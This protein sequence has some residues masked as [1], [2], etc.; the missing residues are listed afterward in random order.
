MLDGKDECTLLEDCS[1]VVN[2]LSFTVPAGFTW[3]GASIPNVFWSV[4]FVSPFHHTVRRAGLL[5]DY[6]YR[7]RAHRALAD[8]MF[9]ATMK[10]DGANWA[11]RTAMY[12]AVRMFGWIFYKGK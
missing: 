11:Q 3:D 8:A 1:I 7:R 10:M 12:L 4:L 2:D 5:H 6:L 9:L